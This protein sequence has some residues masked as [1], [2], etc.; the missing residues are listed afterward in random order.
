[1]LFFN[2][3]N[4]IP[5]NGHYVNGFIARNGCLALNL[6]NN[7][8]C[9]MCLQISQHINNKLLLESKAN[10]FKSSSKVYRYNK[11]SLQVSLKGIKLWENVIFEHFSLYPYNVVKH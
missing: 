9:N 1:M 5:L 10:Y 6:K 4:F 3:D 2:N 8:F 7:N 11:N